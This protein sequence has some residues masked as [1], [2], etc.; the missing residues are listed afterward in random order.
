MFSPNFKSNS[1]R[2]NDKNKYYS[3]KPNLKLLSD[4]ESD[5]DN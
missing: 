3:N 5:S 1:N 2:H 4:I